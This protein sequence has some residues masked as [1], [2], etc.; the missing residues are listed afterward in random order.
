[1]SACKI[2]KRGDSSQVVSFKAEHS[3]FNHLIIFENHLK[4]LNYFYGFLFFRGLIVSPSISCPKYE[5]GDCFC[6]LSGATV[7]PFG[8]I[9]YNKRSLEEVG[10]PGIHF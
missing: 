7:S 3:Q 10:L 4:F 5:K 2:L 6:P 1:V 9:K 8:Q